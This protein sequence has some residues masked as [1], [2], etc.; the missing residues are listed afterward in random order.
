MEIGPAN[1]KKTKHSNAI[2]NSGEGFVYSV[3]ETTDPNSIVVYYHILLDDER[4]YRLARRHA[5]MSEEAAQSHI[6]PKERLSDYFFRSLIILALE[7][8]KEYYRKSLEEF[9]RVYQEVYG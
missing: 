8:R 5:K 1:F 4:G 2:I 6:K 7:P 3:D 9:A